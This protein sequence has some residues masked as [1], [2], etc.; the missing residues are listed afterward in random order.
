VL[1]GKTMHQCKREAKAR[2]K[3]RGR[4]F[5]GETTVTIRAHRLRTRLPTMNLRVWVRTLDGILC[6][7]TEHSVKRNT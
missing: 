2:S 7:P 1:K 4:S 3:A 5:T 6:Q